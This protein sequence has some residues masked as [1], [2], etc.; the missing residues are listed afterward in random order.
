VDTETA[1]SSLGLRNLFSLLLEIAKWSILNLSHHREFIYVGIEDAKR[2][3]M[4]FIAFAETSCFRFL[5]H[6]PWVLARE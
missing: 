6:F 4:H 5:V 2:T 3:E 1:K